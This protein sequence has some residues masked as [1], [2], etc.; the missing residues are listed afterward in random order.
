MPNISKKYSNS[1]VKKVI[2]NKKYNRKKQKI[3]SKQEDKAKRS[4][5]QQNYCKI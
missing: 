1:K 4:H 5:N 3:K 2:K